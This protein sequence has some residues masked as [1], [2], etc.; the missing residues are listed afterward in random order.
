MC[1]RKTRTAM[2]VA[3]RRRALST[4][5]RKHDATRISACRGSPGN[6]QSLL[7]PPAPSE[8]KMFANRGR[9]LP[10]FAKTCTHDTPAPT[11]FEKFSKSTRTH[12]HRANVKCSRI[13][14]E[15]FHDPRK[16]AHTTHPHRRTLRNFK[17]HSHTPAPTD[18]S[19]NVQSPLARPAPSD[20]H[21]M[22]RE[23]WKSS[24]TIRE[25]MHTR[26]TRTDG[27]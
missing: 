9:V 6:F 4:I 15:F 12:P 17:V 22:F 16:H 14:E 18:I 24:S 20:R 19:A 27:L 13:V 11:D 10:R 1:A 5:S 25:N 2:W 26:H 23:S 21:K 7:A 8:R 3:N